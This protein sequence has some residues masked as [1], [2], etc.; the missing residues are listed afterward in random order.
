L[1]IAAFAAMV[2]STEAQDVL[3]QWPKASTTIW[4]GEIWPIKIKDFAVYF[5]EVAKW[6]TNLPGADLNKVAK[7]LWPCRGGV[8]GG[9]K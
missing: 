1:G 6:S 4:L 9:T 2:R 8:Q 7:Q 3:S 5:G